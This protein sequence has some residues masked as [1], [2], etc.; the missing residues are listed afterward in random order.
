MSGAKRMVSEE[1]GTVQYSKTRLQANQC[2]IVHFNICLGGRGIKNRPE[3]QYKN[4]CTR[5]N[6][7]NKGAITNEKH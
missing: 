7:Y 1:V 4:I 6:D 5:Q 2:T 3:K